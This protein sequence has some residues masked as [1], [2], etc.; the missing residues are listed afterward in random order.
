ML[1]AKRSNKPPVIRKLGSLA[2]GPY[3]VIVDAL[4]MLVVYAID[5]MTPLGVPVWLFYFIPLLLSFWSSRYYA[6]PTVC[7]VTLLFLLAGFIFSPQGMPVS[8]ALLYRFAFS[9][10]FISS[11]ALLWMIRRQQ[12]RTEILQQS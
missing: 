1:S 7:I 12:I 3:I 10:I 8:N 2:S 6:I 9:L 11:S 5:I 4:I